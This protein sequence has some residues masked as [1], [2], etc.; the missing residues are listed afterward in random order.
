MLPEYDDNVKFQDEDSEP[1]FMQRLRDKKQK[2]HK[3]G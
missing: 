1:V 2:L 3:C